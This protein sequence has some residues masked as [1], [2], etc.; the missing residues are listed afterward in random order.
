MQTK[1]ALEAIGE[2]PLIE[3]ESVRPDGGA[4]I[5]VKW[6][7]ANPTGSMKDRM[8]VAII[9]GA[10]ADGE[11]EAGQHVVEFTGGSTGSSLALVCGVSEYPL[12]LVTADCFA[13][14]KIR[15]M[16]ALGADV[17][18][19]E[20]PDG[21]IHPGLMDEWRERVHEIVEE[22]DAFFTDQ[23]HNDHHLEGYRPL[24]A[25]IVADCPVI[26]DFVMGVGTGG[27]AMGT[28]AGIRE[29][30][31]DVTVTLVEPSESSTLTEGE[32]G[33]HTIEGVA[34]GID[35]PF[36]EAD[37]YDDAIAVPEETAYRV[38]GQIARNDGVFAGTSTGL[39]VAAAVEVARDRD[40]TDAVVTIAVDTGLK[41]LHGDLYR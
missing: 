34:L 12:T 19:L 25:E 30:R 15:T 16:R 18:V 7:G 41:Y 21:E 8:A 9:R 17:E 36:V 31:D 33:S 22:L 28:A 13:E 38:A 35:P 4:R 40:P 32:S 37:Q 6:E 1:S 27:G 2:T 39:N 11:L 20:T 29:E 26:S 14:E 24:G 5:F 23:F 10:E 3:L